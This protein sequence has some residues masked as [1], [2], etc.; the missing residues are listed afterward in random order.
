MSGHRRA[1]RLNKIVLDALEWVYNKALAML[2]QPAGGIGIVEKLDS[3]Y[4]VEEER[5][6]NI[7][8]L[9]TLC[10]EAVASPTFFPRDGRSYC[11]FAAQYIA[12]GMGFFGFPANTLAN[13]MIDLLAVTPGWVEDTIERAHRHAMRGGLAFLCLT[14]YPHGHLAAVYPAPMEPSGTWGE[15]VPVLSNVGQ[16]NGIMK[17]SAV[18]RLET[19]PLIR[20]FLW[21]ETV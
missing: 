2:T 14:D 20:A 19:R 8:R 3:G 11:N 1:G 7:E 12:E 17:T 18:Y 13:D 10:D 15:D 16:K 9:K 5:M 6:G 21:G 4:S